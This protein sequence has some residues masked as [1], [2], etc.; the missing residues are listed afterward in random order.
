[1]WVLYQSGFQP[2][3]H[4]GGMWQPLAYA[5]DALGVLFGIFLILALLFIASLV[6]P[7]LLH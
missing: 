6:V 7:F 2:P 4:G 5:I 1:M 3:Q